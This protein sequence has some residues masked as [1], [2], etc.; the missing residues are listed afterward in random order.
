MQKAGGERISRASLKMI[1][2]LMTSPV[3]NLD[4]GGV[5]QV[6]EVG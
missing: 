2:P 6:Q 3:S 5:I 1:Q 4:E